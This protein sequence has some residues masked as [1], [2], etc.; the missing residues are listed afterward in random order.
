MT[1]DNDIPDEMFQ[2][3]VVADWALSEAC[4][5]P[6]YMMNI[7]NQERVPW[8]AW[9]RLRDTYRPAA[10]TSRV[11]LVQSLRFRTSQAGI[12]STFIHAL[13][14]Q[15]SNCHS[16]SVESRMATYWSSQDLDARESITAL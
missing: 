14:V 8:R 15:I 10:V 16:M 7:I 9:E 3:V 2:R 5:D 6:S 12:I 4:G 13:R 1:A 11:S